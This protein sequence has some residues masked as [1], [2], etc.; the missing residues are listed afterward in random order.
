MKK[1]L[2]V[3]LLALAATLCLAFALSACSPAPNDNTGN[4]TEQSGNTGNSGNNSSDSG[5]TEE[6]DNKTPTAGL[7][8]TLNDDGATYTCTGIGRAYPNDIVIASQIEGKPVT[9]IGKGA[10]SYSRYVTKITIPESITSIGENAF[11]YCND[12]KE[13]HINNI[14]A[15][16]NIDFGNN[17]AN[18]LN[19][20]QHL[21]VNDELAIQLNIPQGVDHIK[22]YAFYKCTSLTDITI[23]DSVTSIGNGTFEDCEN[24]KKVNFG[25]DSKLETIGDSAFNCTNLDRITIPDSV[26]SI[27]GYAFY[28]CRS[29]TSIGVL[30]NVTSVGSAAFMDCRNLIG[31]NFDIDSK[32]KTIGDEA[33]WNCRS[34]ASINFGS[35]SGLETIGDKAFR[36]CSNLTN[37]TIPNGVTSIG[38]EAFMNCEKLESTTIPD[39]VTSIGKMTFCNCTSLLSVTFENKTGWEVSGYGYK[40]AVNVDDDANNAELLKNTYVTYYWKRER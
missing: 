7:A 33:F 37:I 32:L 35:N 28:N 22:D 9:A 2:L 1:R 17:T 34:L 23:S 31:V 18:P 21:Y 29:L 26:T 19:Y 27:G 24:L 11:M 14:V 40:Q 12:L 20:A 6:T 16:C 5:N 8:Y 36:Y 30:A 4:T 3:I 25:T 15:W 10:F 13:V 38:D 39:N